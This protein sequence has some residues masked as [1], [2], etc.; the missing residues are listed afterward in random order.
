MSTYDVLKMV[1]RDMVAILRD[2]LLLQLAIGVAFIYMLKLAYRVQK[3]A[4]HYDWMSVIV[5]PDGQ[6]SQ[7]KTQ[8]VIAF[9]VVTWIVVLY[10]SRGTLSEMMFGL[11]FGF[12]TA[13][14]VANRYLNK[15]VQIAPQ[16]ATVTTT[17][18][19]GSTTTVT[20]SA[21]PL[22]DPDTGLPVTP[23]EPQVS[24]TATRTTGE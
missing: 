11:Y 22:T 6:I 18:P 8:Q 14:V 3:A 20:A 23:A 16:P 10:A 15:D 7:V 2:G 5:G 17:V 13:A 1:I 9:I 12:T 4:D 24:V 21:P 19:A